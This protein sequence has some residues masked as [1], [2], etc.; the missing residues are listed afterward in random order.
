MILTCLKEAIPE[1]IQPTIGIDTN[2]WNGIPHSKKNLFHGFNPGS[3]NVT[4]VLVPFW[5]CWMLPSCT[6]F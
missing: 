5:S 3:F 1:I 2:G 4:Y 6:A